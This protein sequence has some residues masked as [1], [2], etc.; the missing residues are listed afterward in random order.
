MEHHMSDVL[1]YIPSTSS[2]ILVT[3]ILHQ[4]PSCMYEEPHEA[5]AGSSASNSLGTPRSTF[6]SDQI[7]KMKT[8]PFNKVYYTNSTTENT[9]KESRLKDCQNTI[10]SQ[11]SLPSPLDEKEIDFSISHES[12]YG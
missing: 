4:D 9:L 11:D 1:S 3:A 6:A 8:V 7:V 10:Q 2:T 12:S 5:L